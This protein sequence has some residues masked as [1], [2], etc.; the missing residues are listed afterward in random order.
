MRPS[1]KQL[2]S[3]GVMLG[4]LLAASCGGGGG[5]SPSVAPPPASAVNVVP[6]IID[7]GPTNGSANTLFATVTVCV[8]GSTTQ[9]QTIDHIQVDTGSVGF[10][11]LA[12]VLT[13]TLPSTQVSAGNALAECT[14]FADGYSWGP[15]ATAD[16]TI[17]G[18]VATSLPIQVIG[19]STFSLAPASCSSQ[20]K[21]A[22]QTVTAF[23]ANG[24]L[25]IGVFPTDCAT[26]TCIAAYNR[27]YSCASSVC[28]T[29]DVAQ[30][31]Q[32][33]NPISKFVKDNNGSIIQLPSVAAPGQVSLTGSLIFGIDT[34]SNNASGTQTVLGVDSSNGYFT[35]QFAGKTL[36]S[37]I[38][39]GSNGIF[40][41]LPSPAPANLAGI[42]PCPPPTPTASDPN[43]PD[44][45]GFYCPA[46]PTIV[47]A[48]L[49]GTNNV[50]VTE[51]FTVDN[52][53]TLATTNPTFSVLPTLSGTFPS[54]PSNDSFDWGLP[55]FYGRRVANAI[56]LQTT[57]VG[58]GPYVAF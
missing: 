23:G 50:S 38:D 54:T 40:F 49:T 27:Y 21:Q 12:S 14:V 29:I 28:N 17:G 55:F 20:G 10:R 2:V 37:F 5:G 1:F 3:V 25:G 56:E 15:V 58:T 24:I 52:A 35:T 19:V 6:V 39:S 57:A 30:M 47:S 9:C 18:E 33:Q 22:E 48:V 13:L 7:A 44:F 11:V 26:G 34:E 36:Q 53:E 42:V 31:S 4:G 32:V 51:Q 46:A 16:L 41:N 43:P 45:T 8:P